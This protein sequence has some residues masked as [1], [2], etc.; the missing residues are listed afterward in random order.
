LGKYGKKI[1]PSLIKKEL[2]YEPKSIISQPL[3]GDVAINTGIS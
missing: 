2:E 3:S 1:I